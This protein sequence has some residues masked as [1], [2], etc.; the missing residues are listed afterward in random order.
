M[1]RPTEE[2]SSV[3][4]R[5]LKGAVAG[6]VGVMALDFVTELMTSAE[7]EETLEREAQARPDAMDPAHVVAN[8]AA[9]ALGYR[10]EPR[11]PHPAG[12]ATHFA[13]GVLPASLYGLSHRSRNVNLGA[14]LLLG[15]GMMVQDEGLNYALG[16]SGRPEEYP[17]EAHA[18]GV[19][20]H[21]A[22][23]TATE[24]TLA[25]MN[26]VEARIRDWS[27]RRRRARGREAGDAAETWGGRQ[28]ETSDRPESRPPPSST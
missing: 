9:D 24:C 16:L 6:A 28:R 13:F 25:A 14:G 5:L 11:Q 12:I 2:E 15:L 22:F 7:D 17:R 3:I 8:R 1:A 19:V 18:R 23:G 20:G 21:L 10:L 4:G 27:E 26:A